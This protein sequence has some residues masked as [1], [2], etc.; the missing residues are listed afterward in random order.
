MATRIHVP[1]VQGFGARRALHIRLAD[2]ADPHPASASLAFGETLVVCDSCVARVV[3]AEIV[4]HEDETRRESA[5][6][7]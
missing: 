2:V 1:H 5:A 3:L 7:R 6:N 4:A